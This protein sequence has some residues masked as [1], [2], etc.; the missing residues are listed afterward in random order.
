MQNQQ[1]AERPQVPQHELVQLVTKVQ[2]SCGCGAV[3]TIFRN[4]KM[5]GKISVHAGKRKAA[6]S[7]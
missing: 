1:V 7:S 3:F 4:V 5:L 6:L 2:Y